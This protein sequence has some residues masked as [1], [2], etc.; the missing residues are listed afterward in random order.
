MEVINIE[1]KDGSP[2]VILDKENGIFLFSGKS[3]PENAKDFYVRIINWLDEY[4]KV[5]NP[6]TTVIFKMEYFNT[7]SSKRILDVFETLTEIIYN[8]K[9]VVIDWYY[10]DIDSEMYNAGKEYANI[11]NIPFNFIPYEPE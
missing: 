8:G 4:V 11:I 5:P 3:L 6:V 1:E 9:S 2:K 7:A 10:F